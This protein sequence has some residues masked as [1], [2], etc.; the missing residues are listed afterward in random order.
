[1]YFTH[2][3]PGTGTG[4]SVPLKLVEQGEH[5]TIKVQPIFRH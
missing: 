3:S 1:M 5:I 4:Y 2:F